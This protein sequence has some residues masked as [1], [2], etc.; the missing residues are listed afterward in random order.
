MAQVYVIFL[1]RVS[2]ELI[3]L[4]SRY[5][6]CTGQLRCLILERN[7]ELTHQNINHILVQV[8]WYYLCREA[9]GLVDLVLSFQNSMNDINETTSQCL[10]NETQLASI[11]A[12]TMTNNLF[13]LIHLKLIRQQSIESGI[14]GYDLRTQ[15]FKESAR[16]TLQIDDLLV[17]ADTLARVGLFAAQNGAKSQE[18]LGVKGTIVSR[19]CGNDD[20]NL[21]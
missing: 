6:S 13:E 17:P 2:Q 16:T 15:H 18:S 20:T 1:T 11:F 7:E 4:S 10:V 3:L 21:W 14:L 12:I 9:I 5:S 19:H 8:P